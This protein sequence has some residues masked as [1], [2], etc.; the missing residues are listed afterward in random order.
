[1]YQLTSDNVVPMY[2]VQF[3]HKYKYDYVNNIID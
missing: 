3:N 1:M 2:F